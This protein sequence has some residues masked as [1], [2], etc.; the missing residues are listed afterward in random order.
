MQLQGGIMRASCFGTA[1]LCTAAVFCLSACDGEE[2]V[3]GD[4]PT[5][6]SYKVIAQGWGIGGTGEQYRLV[7]NQAVLDNL[8]YSVGQRPAA[9]PP[10]VDFASEVAYFATLGASPTT[11]YGIA[12]EGLRHSGSTG[13]AEDALEVDVKVFKP[14]PSCVNATVVTVPYVIITFP[15]AALNRGVINV[16]VAEQITN[17]GAGS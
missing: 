17:C 10:V 12:I 3:A 6:V 9:L 13:A 7:E 14:A 2:F 8:F 16:N 1:M 11:G 15:R 5:A 4:D